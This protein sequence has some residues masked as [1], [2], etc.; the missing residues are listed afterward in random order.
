MKNNTTIIFITDYKNKGSQTN[1]PLLKIQ[2][3]VCLVGSQSLTITNS[4]NSS[5]RSLSGPPDA[6]LEQEG[7]AG[8]HYRIGAIECSQALTGEENTSPYA[9]E[10]RGGVCVI[11]FFLALLFS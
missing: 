10:G 1:S 9:N 4:C 2:D 11:M 5:S 7:D 6:L 8:Q 3:D